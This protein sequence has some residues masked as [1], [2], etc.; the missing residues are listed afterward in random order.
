MIADTFT[1]L[2]RNDPR[3][4]A[5]GSVSARTAGDG[6]LRS[7]AMITYLAMNPRTPASPPQQSEAATLTTNNNTS[8]VETV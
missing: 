8:R 7:S 1:A 6:V 2:R 4:I 5:V 3:T